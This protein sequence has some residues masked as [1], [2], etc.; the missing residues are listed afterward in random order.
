MFQTKPIA[1]SSAVVAQFTSLDLLPPANTSE[2]PAAIE[3]LKSK[4]VR[5]SN[6]HHF[7]SRTKFKLCHPSQEEKS[8]W[9]NIMGNEQG[10]TIF[11][12]PLNFCICTF[13]ED[14]WRIP[15]FGLNVLMTIFFPLFSGW[16]RQADRGEINRDGHSKNFPHGGRTTSP[17]GIE[18]R[19]RCTDHGGCPEIVW[20]SPDRHD[21]RHRTTSGGRTGSN[22]VDPWSK[23]YSVRVILHPGHVCF[24]FHWGRKSH[25]RDGK[26]DIGGDW[27]AE[28]IPETD[29]IHDG[30][31]LRGGFV[32]HAVHHGEHGREQ[33]RGRRRGIERAIC[34][35]APRF[36]TK[37]RVDRFRSVISHGKTAVEDVER[38]PAASLSQ[39]SSVER[40][41][42]QAGVYCTVRVPWDTADRWGIC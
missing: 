25:G 34:H 22:P 32:R 23:S 3:A 11:H 37:F 31:R 8:N 10:Q 29:V 24:K 4:K 19:R 39:S 1:H 28:L 40:R 21:Q 33:R 2:V 18:C 20:S 5:N 14:I 26:I 12:S 9:G 36:G 17:A 38:P 35:T 16:S 7:G 42:K 6:S 13:T 15:H 30:I 27:I 41:W